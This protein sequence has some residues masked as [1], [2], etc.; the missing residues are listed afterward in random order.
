MVILGMLCYVVY[1]NN[2]YQSS[3]VIIAILTYICKIHFYRHEHNNA[4]VP[5]HCQKQD[6]EWVPAI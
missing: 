1:Y 6:R 4:M 3:S 5:P 2:Q